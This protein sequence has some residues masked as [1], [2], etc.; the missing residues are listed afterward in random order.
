M[1]RKR[2]GN[3]RNV[4]ENGNFLVP[5]S[6]DWLEPQFFFHFIL[7]EIGYKTTVRFFVVFER[8]V[9]YFFL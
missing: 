7:R 8:E 1:I 9:L 2:N 5:N 3:I 4:Y 6:L